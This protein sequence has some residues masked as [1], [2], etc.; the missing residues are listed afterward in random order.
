MIA[1]LFQRYKSDWSDVFVSKARKENWPESYVVQVLQALPS[2][3]QTWD[4]AAS[5]GDSVRLQYWRSASVYWARDNEDEVAFG[6]QQLIDAGRARAAIYL[7][8]G[9]R[10]QL[11]AR[12][13]VTM[14]TDAV[15]EPRPDPVDLSEATMFQWSVGQLLLRLDT[16]D[17]VSEAEVAQLEWS[18][19]TVLEHSERSPIVLHRSMA[20]DPS[21]FVQILS[22]VFRAH[23]ESAPEKGQVSEETK[24]LALH[25]SRLLDSWNTIPGA[26]ESGIDGGILKSWVTEAHQL[27]VRAERGVQAGAGGES[28]AAPGGGGG[29]LS[30]DCPGAARGLPPGVFDGAPGGAPR[31]RFAGRLPAGACP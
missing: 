16:D 26:T 8:A 24:A 11:P 20:R 6:V 28:A 15:K 4:I 17:Q 22:A 7:T 14:L 12:L 13:I 1:A 10:Q 23:S 31:Y 30:G 5:F 2:G 25:A 3:K 21:L 29:F 18:Y 19:L 27:S 9:S